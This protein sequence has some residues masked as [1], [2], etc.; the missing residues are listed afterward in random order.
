MN[1]SVDLAHLKK[2]IMQDIY[3]NRMLLTSKR[4]RP[5]GWTL[6][7]GL[8]S[9]FYIQLRILSS[10]PST[11][12]KVGVAMTRLI[13]EKV[14]HVDRIVGIAFAGVP[15]ATAISLESRIPSCH[16]RKLSGVRSSD[17]LS[18]ALSSYGQHSLLEGEINDGDV[19]CLV[20]DLVT[21]MT[22]KLVA[23]DQIQAEIKR[24]NLTDVICEDIV[25]IVDRQQGAVEKAKAA[26]L[27]LYSLIDFVDEGL[28]FLKDLMVKE[29]YE[30]VS[31]YL[32][33]PQD[34]QP[35]D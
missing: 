1:T 10:F 33:N 19:L 3:N 29:E 13:H 2:E 15:I 22:S 28:P 25:V 21:G 30:L 31:G 12:K 26:G 27:N 18:E 34:F 35:G 16:T 5:E 17:E 4:D 11:L 8:W 20:D 7:S 23:R 14:P 24:R 9:P 6:H 32:T